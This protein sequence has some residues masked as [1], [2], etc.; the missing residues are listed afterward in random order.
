MSCAS[1]RCTRDMHSDN[2]VTARARVLKVLHKVQP[3]K[4]AV[5]AFVG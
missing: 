5:T 2:A 3:S 4:S 1:N